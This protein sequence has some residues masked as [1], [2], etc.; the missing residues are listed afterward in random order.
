VA[1]SL[2]KRSIAGKFLEL[3]SDSATYG[4]STVLTRVVTFLLLPL[5][6]RF[7]DKEAY[8]A[9]AM[10]ELMN[11]VFIPLA[12]F[13]MA[14]ATFR[15][16]NLSKQSDS[17]DEVFGTALAST[18]AIATF[19]F[20]AAQLF[21]EQITH[22]LVA[23]PKYVFLVRLS[24]CSAY[25]QSLSRTAY[26]MMRSDR[27]AKLLASINLG[28]VVLSTLI[29][30]WLVIFMRWGVK[31]V[32][33]AL[34]TAEIVALPIYYSLTL[35]RFRPRPSFTRWKQMVRYGAPFVPH[36]IQAL[37]IASF[38][39]YMVRY[40]LSLEQAG[41]YQVAVRFAAPAALI[42]TA[43]QTAWVPFKFQVHAEDE[44]PAVFFGTA[45]TYYVLLVSY[46]WMGIAVWG[47][48]VVRLMT[49]EAFHGAALFT[50][51]VAAI[52]ISRGIYFMTSSGFEL[53]DDTRVLPLVSFS[54]LIVVVS[55][56]LFW[57][58]RLDAFGAPIAT[59]SGWIVM[60]FFIY[61]LSQRRFAVKYDWKTVGALLGMALA[62]ALM[63]LRLQDQ[64]FAARIAF[65]A[66]TTL[67]FPIAGISLITFGGTD[68]E[69]LRRG[70]E[71]LRNRG[72]RKRA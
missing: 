27:R 1:G 30:V 19:L 45:M 17:R 50:P 44:Q 33:V 10:F 55:S 2:G 11:L 15:H 70:W 43:I 3:A 13:G 16:F 71:V 40:L 35:R 20:V 25:L 22:I 23:E 72:R 62:I 64:T 5:Y 46:L 37:G 58:P 24:L 57:I 4:A 38:G 21:A 9:L 48:E 36:Q 59:V 29:T 34:L 26:V 6:T 28:K 42:I 68:S 65:A 12:T 39:V 51:L 49:T 47:P 53:T 52:P 60:S 66:V 7:L 54:G 63:A 18:A 41:V 61:K 32:V 56:A 31:G 14:T 8:G 67:L 69:P